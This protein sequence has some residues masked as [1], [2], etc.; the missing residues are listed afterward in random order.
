M[1]EPVFITVTVNLMDLGPFSSAIW[2]PFRNK[3]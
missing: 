1:I 3:H 2:F